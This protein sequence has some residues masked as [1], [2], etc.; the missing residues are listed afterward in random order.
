MYDTG[1]I[2]ATVP[3]RCTLSS[4]VA[5]YYYTYKYQGHWLIVNWLFELLIW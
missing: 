4:R 5:N 1:L 3:H 2:N